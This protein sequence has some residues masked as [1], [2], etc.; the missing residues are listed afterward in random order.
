M[1]NKKT[2]EILE[3]ELSL[4][5]EKNAIL[6]DRAEATEKKFA[7]ANTTIGNQHSR[8]VDLTEQNS[9]TLGRFQ[10]ILTA[11]DIL[12]RASLRDRGM[13]WED[14]ER[15]IETSRRA[16]IMGNNNRT[17]F[18]GSASIGRFGM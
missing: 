15:L 4:E 9:R 10:E 18:S 3:K 7:D 1:A 16:M 17:D 13:A 12:L 5:Q 8:I 11:H 2:R 14:I 6:S